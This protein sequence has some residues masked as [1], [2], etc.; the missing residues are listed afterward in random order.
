MKVMNVALPQLQ[1][2]LEEVRLQGF[3]RRRRLAT[4]PRASTPTRSSRAFS[5]SAFENAKWAYDAG[6]GHRAQEGREDRRRR[7][8]VPSARACRPSA[9]PAPSR[10]SVKVGLGHGNLGA[11][12]L[13]RGDRVLCLPGRPRVLRRRRGRHR[14]RPQRQQGP[15]EPPARH[16][17]RPGQGRRA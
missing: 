3:R 11:M 9:S 6:R 5:P 7:R 2:V 12:L 16:P 1:P 10:I 13:R 8:R 17:Q 14:H 4:T 15:Q